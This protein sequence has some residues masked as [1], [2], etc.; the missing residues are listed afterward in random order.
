VLT[1]ILPPVEAAAPIIDGS[2][3]G[4]G[5]APGA[6]ATDVADAMD[7]GGG[8]IDG[9][10]EAGSKIA[11][12]VVHD[13]DPSRAALWS[14][15]RDFEIGTTGAHPWGDVRWLGTYFTSLEPVATILLGKDW[16]AVSA[17]SKLYV[18]G[19]QATLTL[20]APADLYMLVD[21]RWMPTMVPAW[22]VGWADIGAN[23]IVYESVDRPTLPFSLFHRTVPAGP[24]D[25]PM[26]GDN[27]G[28]NYVIVVN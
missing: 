25:L 9:P 12:L 28:Y 10:G 6:D 13:T 27:T 16:I 23:T 15:R 2:D 21:D 5:G 4:S 26:I 8:S 17:E 7:G 11:S 18:G 3:T 22:T 19:P 14:V 20:N 1:A 24:L